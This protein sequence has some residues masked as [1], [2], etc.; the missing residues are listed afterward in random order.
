MVILRLMLAPVLILAAT[1]VGRRWG[2][3]LAGW[4]VAL[5]LTSAPAAFLLL[6][7]QGPAFAGHAAN[8]ML[9]GTASQVAF[10][11]SYRALAIRGSQVALITGLLGF[12]ASTAV[13]AMVALT[14][15]F[16]AAL[17]GMVLVASHAVIV[18]HPVRS[19]SPTSLRRPAVWELPLRMAVAAGIVFSITAAAPLIGAH[20]AGLLSPLPVFAAVLTVFTHLHESADKAKKVLDGLVFGLI[21]PAIFF[22]VL[23]A[24]V[25][26]AGSGAF[27]LATCA[28]LL[29][30][31]LTAVSLKKRGLLGT[32]VGH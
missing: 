13:L 27:A 30:Q 31:G 32:S 21:S 18:Q 29:T 10:A 22:L 5:P 15:P 26:V 28:A 8:G 3:A 20:L 2:P 23:A 4:L 24:S 17:V 11:L 19:T 14:L 25:E 6:H 9:A 7:E 1:L 16:T 12:A